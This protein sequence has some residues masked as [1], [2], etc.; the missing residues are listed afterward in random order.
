MNVVT[1]CRHC[2]GNNRNRLPQES[3]LELLYAPYVP[4]KAEYL[5]LTNRRILADQVLLQE[6]HLVGENAAVGSRSCLISGAIA[7]FTCWDATS[8]GACG[9]PPISCAPITCGPRSIRSRNRARKSIGCM[10][11]SWKIRSEEHT[12]ELQSPMYLVCRLLLEK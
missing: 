1:A 8:R 3:G 5:I 4:N 11:L 10:P 12:S 2:N 9:S 6:L 7:A